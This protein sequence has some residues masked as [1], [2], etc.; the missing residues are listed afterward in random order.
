MLESVVFRWK[1]AYK[2]IS[3]SG[4]SAARLCF[5]ERQSYALNHM[6]C[7]LKF[8]F[9]ATA[10]LCLKT[11]TAKSCLKNFEKKST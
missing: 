2:R 3:I 5:N 11:V 1:Q 8:G 6:F 4:L 7:D 9:A 10:K